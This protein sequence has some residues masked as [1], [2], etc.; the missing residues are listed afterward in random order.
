MLQNKNLCATV[1]IFYPSL[2][3]PNLYIK[4][5]KIKKYKIY[6]RKQ[7]NTLENVLNN[8]SMF[9]GTFFPGENSIIKNININKNDYFRF[10]DKEMKII[11]KQIDKRVPIINN[12][13]LYKNFCV[14]FKTAIRPKFKK[15]N[16]NPNFFLKKKIQNIRENAIIIGASNGLGKRF[17]E[18][19]IFNKNINIIACYNKN[20]IIKKYKKVFPL[21]LDVNRDLDK[22]N[23]LIKKFHPLKIYYFATPKILINNKI[24]NIQLSEFNR[25]FLNIPLKILKQNKSNKISFFYPSTEFIKTKSNIAYSKVKKSAEKKLKK[26]CKYH[27]IKLNLY[28]FPKLNSKQSISLIEKDLP[29]LVEHLNNNKNKITKIFN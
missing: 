8:L 23:Y 3:G 7:K 21:K 24:S 17:L 28:R 2:S 6:R 13:L 19:L 14:N 20:K 27:K 29:D 26:Y 16:I 5:K 12:S 25:Y 18:L 4:G 11:Y 15:K 22:L 9:V 1:K 10:S